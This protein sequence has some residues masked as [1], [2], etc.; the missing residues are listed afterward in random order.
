MITSRR[1]EIRLSTRLEAINNDSW[2]RSRS[3][4]VQMSTITSDCNTSTVQNKEG[5]TFCRAIKCS[6]SIDQ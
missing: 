6:L 1:F 5:G 2:R 4:I 3:G